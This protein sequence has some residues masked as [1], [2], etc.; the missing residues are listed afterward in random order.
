MKNNKPIVKI[1]YFEK[2][3]EFFKNKDKK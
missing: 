1:D 2:L 3:K